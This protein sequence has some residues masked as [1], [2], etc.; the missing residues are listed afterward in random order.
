MKKKLFSGILCVCMLGIGVGVPTYAADMGTVDRENATISVGESHALVVKEDGSLWAWGSNGAG[1]IG[2][3][4]TEDRTQPVKILDDVVSVSA[5][6][7]N[8]FAIQKDGTLWGWGNN[9]YNQIGNGGVSDSEGKTIGSYSSTVPIVTKPQKVLDDVTMVSSASS[10]TLALKKD[11]SVWAWGIN[12]Y[13][14]GDETKGSQ[15]TPVKVLDGAVSI[16]AGGSASAAIKT[17]GSLWLWGSY[18]DPQNGNSH[19]QDNSFVPTPKKIMD[20]VKAVSVGALQIAVIKSDNT[21]VHWGT[22]NGNNAFGA[23]ELDKNVISVCASTGL[24]GVGYANESYLLFMKA[25]HSLWAVG[26]S[27][28]WAATKDKNSGISQWDHKPFKVMDNVKTASAGDGLAAVM[29]NDGSVYELSWR[30]NTRLVLEGDNNADHAEQSQV[31][32][33]PTAATV[34]VNGKTIA[35]D[36]YE[37]GGNNYFKL[38]DIAQVL[39]GS[40]KQFEVQYIKESDSIALTANKSY[41][42]VGG[43]LTAATQSGAITAKQ[44]TQKVLLNDKSCDLTAYNIYNNNYFKLRDLG[45]LFDFGVQWDGNLKM[46]TIDTG[47]SYTE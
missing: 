25:D 1:I 37:I 23:Q 11:G 41:T 6:D 21:A 2:D 14:L 35:F 12:Y 27:P 7:N 19:S 8:S 31:T 32:A 4:T 30:A 9:Q 18:P 24:S 26:S 38:R 10:H 44:S 33:K 42:S 34:Q 20:D 39:N 46:I 13:A 17:D 5:S 29:K 15:N 16:A 47:M 22:W 45:K 28:A 36:A 40:Q 3:G 43:E